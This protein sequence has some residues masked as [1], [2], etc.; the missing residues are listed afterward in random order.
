MYI[1]FYCIVQYVYAI[2]QYIYGQR[3]RGEYE[4]GWSDLLYQL[5]TNLLVYL[6]KLAKTGSFQP[7]LMWCELST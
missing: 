5:G 7:Y 4:I 6:F 1:V 3:I 2:L